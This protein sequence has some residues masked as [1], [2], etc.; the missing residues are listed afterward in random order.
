VML[1]FVLIGASTL[2]ALVAIAWATRIDGGGAHNRRVDSMIPHQTKM[3][4]PIPRY[5]QR[6]LLTT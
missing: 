6:G 4:D 3:F 2:L 1:N 5:F